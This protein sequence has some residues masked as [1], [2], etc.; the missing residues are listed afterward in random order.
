MKSMPILFLGRFYS[1]FSL[2]SI[3]GFWIIIISLSFMWPLALYTYKTVNKFRIFMANKI[4]NLEPCGDSSNLYEELSKL[5]RSKIGSRSDK[6][7]SGGS[8]GNEY[9][10]M[11]GGKNSRHGANRRGVWNYD[12]ASIISSLSG[13]DGLVG[14]RRIV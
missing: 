10:L 1:L 13:G 7:S 5:P 9:V 11:L 3:V 2:P 6:G 8:G 12:E 14:L 4:I